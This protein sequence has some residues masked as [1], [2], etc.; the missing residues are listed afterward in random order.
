MR[1]R[2]SAGLCLCLA[3]AACTLKE[4]GTGAPADVA[5]PPADALRTPSGLASKVL[6]VGVGM[7][8]PQ[9]RSTVVVHYTGWTPK[10]EKFDS[11]VDRGTPAE[12]PLTM[13]IPG[14]IEGLQMMA[15]GEKRRFWIPGELA[16]AKDTSKPPDMRGML[17]F[18]VEL[19]A[20]K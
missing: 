1:R 20:V 8:R 14:W 17:V 7:G 16:Y 10:G 13:V 2:I 11:S 12:F 18:D 19:L 6:R 4:E 15:V 3:L 5:A 9:L